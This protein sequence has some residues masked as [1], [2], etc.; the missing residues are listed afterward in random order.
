V[1][2]EEGFENTGD[3][4]EIDVLVNKNFHWA[5]EGLGSNCKALLPV[6]GAFK[7]YKDVLPL[8][9]LSC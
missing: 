7:R 4:P 3:Q 9:Y 1:R 2:F 8:Q 6:G 5:L